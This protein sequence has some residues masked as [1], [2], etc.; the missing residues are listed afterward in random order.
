MH[1]RLWVFLPLLLVVSTA[2]GTDIYKCTDKNGATSYGD[3]PCPS[4]QTTLLHKGTAAEAAQAKQ[5]Q[6]IVALNAMVDSG[7]LDEA[8]NF[9][10]LNGVSAEFQARV[11]ANI[12]RDQEQ[13]RQEMAKDAEIERA[14]KEAYQARRQQAMQAEQAKLVQADAAQEKFRKDHWTE[15]KQQNFSDVLSA[16]SPTFNA[17]RGKWCSVSKEDGSTVCQ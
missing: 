8:R 2:N 13:R 9:A 12:S 15:I 11:Q 5:E 7:H 1:A 4:Q 3:K 16:Q 14:N 10:A 6:T 17:A